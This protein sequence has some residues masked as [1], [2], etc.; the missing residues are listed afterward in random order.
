MRFFSFILLILST[1]CCQAVCTCDQNL[2]QFDPEKWAIPQSLRDDGRTTSSRS[3]VQFMLEAVR[4]KCAFRPDMA[5]REFRLW[6]N[7]VRMA[8]EK[9]M[10]FPPACER[11]APK[12]TASIKRDGYRVEKWEAYPLPYAAVPFLLLI[13]DDVSAQQPA[14]A[15]FCF[16][17]SG[18]TK[19]LLAGEPPSG[20]EDNAPAR[21]PGPEA[22]AYHCVREGWV[23]VVVDNGGSGEQ[24]DAERAAGRTSYDDENLARFLLELDWSWLGY[25]SYMNQCI[26]DWVRELPP[27]RDDRIVMCGFS[28]GTEPMMALGV[29][30]PDICAFVYNDFLCRTLERACVMTMPDKR[31]YR[32]P[33]NSIRHLVP[34]F[35][36][37]FDFPDIAASLAP[38]P[39]LCTEGGLDRDFRLVARAYELA[40]SPQHFIGMHQPRFADPADR[41]QGDQLPRG[42]DRK[43]YFRFMNV[44]P[45]NHSFK[46]SVVIPWIK[47]VLAE[48]D[49]QGSENAY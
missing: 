10:K 30:N 15:V 25:T 6:Q 21:E 17:G 35:W 8:M 44:D 4:P 19:E 14:P 32:P 37:R 40:G 31:G 11:P 18:Q 1:A 16:P 28:L 26:L 27:V 33:S 5:R 12:C 29:M 49:R 36:N 41:W 39:L 9:L 38:R 3:I 24:G 47:T 7:R 42:L 2:A 43:G 13:P 20:A 45:S 22:M 46:K 23:A 48:L 34:G